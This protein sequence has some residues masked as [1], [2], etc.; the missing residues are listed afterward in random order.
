[1][2]QLRSFRCNDETWMPLTF[3]SEQTGVTMSE[4]IR[5]SLPDMAMFQ[6]FMQLKAI[7]SDVTWQDT[8]CYGGRRHLQDRY[9]AAAQAHF[10]RLGALKDSPKEVEA[11]IK[12]SIRELEDAGLAD[13][14]LER[15]KQDVVFCGYLREALHK[16][17]GE[18]DGFTLRQVKVEGEP[19]FLVC[20]NKRILT[21][22]G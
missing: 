14:Q 19:K 11:A 10:A 16:A 12:R 13:V 18:Q 3:L 6:L 21:P 15:A 5:Q 17:K 9:V 8:F 20:Y 7:E 2:E 22:R 1:M 4:I